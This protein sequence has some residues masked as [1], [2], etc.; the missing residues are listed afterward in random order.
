MLE[1]NFVFQWIWKYT[2][3]VTFNAFYKCTIKTSLRGRTVKPPE[4]HNYTA[5][6]FKIYI[7]YN[8]FY[9]DYGYTFQDS[10]HQTV[11]CSEGKTIIY[12]E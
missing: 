5:V 10:L 12:I 8:F 11:K 6:V 1:D 7:S 9:A 2:Y 4:R 3:Y